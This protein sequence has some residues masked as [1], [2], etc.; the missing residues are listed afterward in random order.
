MAISLMYIPA[1]FESEET[2]V[3]A[4]AIRVQDFALVLPLMKI[5]RHLAMEK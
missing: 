2:D 3:K 4:L 1:I 5:R